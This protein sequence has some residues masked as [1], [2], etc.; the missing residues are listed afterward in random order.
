VLVNKRHAISRNVTAIIVVVVVLIAAGG[1]YFLLNQPPPTTNTTT[2]STTTSST[3]VTTA[4]SR[5]LTVGS[6]QEPRWLDQ[7]R[8][9]DSIEILVGA[10]VYEPLLRNNPQTGIPEPWLAQ[11]YDVSSDGLT[12][13]F[14][15]R[16]GV[17]FTDG[18]PFNAQAVKATFARDFAEPESLASF[19]G[20]QLAGA[21]ASNLAATATPSIT[22]IDD[23]TVAFKLQS[24]FSP[25]NYMMS[26]ANTGIASPLHN[27]RTLDQFVG[28]GPFTL[29]SWTRT[30]NVKMVP[31]PNYWNKANPDAS[32]K[33][34]TFKFFTS[35][36]ALQSALVTG[37]IDVGV[38]SFT[39]QQINDLSTNANL[40]EI[41]GEIGAFLGIDLNNAT[42]PLNNLQV[43][44]AIFYALN[45]TQIV[46]TAY[47]ASGVASATLMPPNYPYVTNALSAYKQDVTKSKQ[48]LAQAGYSNGFSVDLW[49]SPSHWGDSETA[50]ATLV[51]QQLGAVGINVNIKTS[52]ITTFIRG[53]RAGTPPA[54]TFHW[55]YDYF[56]PYQYLWNL[57]EPAPTGFWGKFIKYND[58]QSTSLLRQIEGTTDTTKLASLY[59]QLQQ[60]AV[61]TVP[62]IPFGF[63]QDV[64]F[65]QNYV[66]GL[67]FQFV[68][69]SAANGAFAQVTFS[70]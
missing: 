28:T 22:V 30:D 32:I 69:S 55:I 35:Q 6:I 4:I 31:N 29:I 61:T 53:A 11:S 64:F 12:Y 58:A 57:M 36:S 52:D 18:A 56:G 33:S 25:F 63:S 14:H 40:K 66:S 24:A 21:N 19:V 51:Q 34:L 3:A 8:I 43:R 42:A 41:K 27:D 48:L 15:L 20:Q 5:D 17:K 2:T 44:Q 46:K 67:Q 23:N 60:R 49:T 65:S 7:T 10:Q 26:M 68:G 45:G 54:L 50:L 62:L 13:T 47:A 59:S 39:P 38:W 1:G 16:Q 37:G 70:R 9:S